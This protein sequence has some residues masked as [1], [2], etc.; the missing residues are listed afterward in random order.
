MAAYDLLI[1]GGTLVDGTGTPRRRSDLGIRDGRIAAIGTLTGATA[2]RTIDATGKVVAP[3]VIDVHTHY[4]GQIFW[5]PWCTN[6]GL[7]GMTT[8][9]VSNCGFGFAPCRQD[10]AV[11]ERYMGMM[12]T[13]EQIPAEALRL[14]LPFTWESFPEWLDVVRALPK[15]V[16]VASYVPL[17]SLMIFVMGSPESARDR[18]PTDD[19][20]ARMQALLREA[21]EAG[22]L[23]FAFSKLDD[24]NSHKDHGAPMPTDA[25]DPSTA[26]RLAE[27]LRDLGRGVI[28]ALVDLPMA[29]DNNHIAEE[30]AAISGRPVIQ[31]IL[32]PFDHIPGEVDRVLK[33]L[34]S[35]EERGLDVYSQALAF[36]AWN[37]SRLLD[38]NTWD[39]V[40]ELARFSSAGDDLDARL[41]IASDPA[42]REALKA[43]YSPELMTSAGGMFEHLRFLRSSSAEHSR[44]EGR[45]FAE[46]A[47]AE[48]VHVVDAF[49]D[50]AVA[51]RCDVDFRTMQAISQDVDLFT[52]MYKHP[53]VIAGT[54][55][56]GAHLKFFCGAQFSTDLLMWLA[57]DERRFRLEELHHKLSLLPASVLGFRDRGALLEGWAADVMVY[58]LDALGYPDQYEIV[59]DLPGGGFRRVT[60]SQ[61]IDAIVVNGEVT[62][63]TDSA[64]TGATPGRVLTA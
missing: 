6:S 36:R 63:E 34:D 45:S 46:I 22:A 56:G 23:G 33:W 16:N 17:N 52:K 38:W 15:G 47:E 40:P 32:V 61:G 12:E 57:R 27:V 58:D 43:K 53:R 39:V 49:F 18:R 59:H 48:G 9:V 60:P 62:F 20:V 51:A 64:C 25:A 3:G 11:Q 4:D 14:A 30:L 44:Y 1:S 19:E 42:W 28:Q 24:F 21:M 41:T 37:E 50:L 29:I 5:D 13:T 54:S 35:C 10:P 55:D 7:H 2:T 31:N 26:Y 8:A